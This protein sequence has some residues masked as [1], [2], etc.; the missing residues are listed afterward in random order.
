MLTTTEFC[1][2]SPRFDVWFLEPILT[3]SVT[4]ISLLNL[5]F[6]GSSFSKWDTVVT[7]HKDQTDDRCSEISKLGPQVKSAWVW[8]VS[9]DSGGLREPAPTRHPVPLTSGV[10]ALLSEVWLDSRMCVKPSSFRT[11]MSR[12]RQLLS[13]WRTL[14]LSLLSKT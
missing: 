7:D 1:W 5:C 8:V 3:N 12:N 6:P 11:T 10:S 14:Y 2:R 13:F 4:M 9:T